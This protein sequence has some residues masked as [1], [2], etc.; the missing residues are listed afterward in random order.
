[1]EEESDLALMS[2]YL[3][4]TK[5]PEWAKQIFKTVERSRNIIMHSGYLEAED[6]ERLGMSLRDWLAQIGG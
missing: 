3:V 2:A 4:T 1:M 6:I 5:N